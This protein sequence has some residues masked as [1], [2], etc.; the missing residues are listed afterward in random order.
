MAAMYSYK[1]LERVLK[2]QCNLIDDKD[3]P[4]ELK[5]PKEI[6]SDSL[7]NP[8]APEATYSGHKG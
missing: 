6:V 2:E 7:Q 4:L 1:M 5:V 8:S 3:N